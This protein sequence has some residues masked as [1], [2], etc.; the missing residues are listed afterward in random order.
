MGANITQ[1]KWRV[2]V[3][4]GQWCD[5]IDW[6]MENVSVSVLLDP[7]RKSNHEWYEKERCMIVD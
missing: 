5:L 2:V 7:D 3:R 1:S 4:V 6:L